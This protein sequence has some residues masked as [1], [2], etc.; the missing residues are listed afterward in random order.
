MYTYIGKP[1]LGLVNPALYAGYRDFIHD[2]TS[3]L[4]NCVI[5]SYQPCCTQGNYLY[6]Y[7]YM[8]MYIY[9]NICAYIYVCIIYEYTFIYADIFYIYMYT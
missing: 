3:G 8:Y 4:N 2:I 1:A 6:T 9:V 7:I 5:S